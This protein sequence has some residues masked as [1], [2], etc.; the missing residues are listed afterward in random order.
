MSCIR[1]TLDASAGGSE[2]PHVAD[3]HPILAAVE[4][5]T[6][7]WRMVAPDGRE[8]GRIELRRVTN[9]ARVRYKTVWRGEVLGWAATL[10]EACWRLHGAYLA[11][12]GP[13]GGP[14]ADWGGRDA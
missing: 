14:V 7:V 4:G 11:A 8:Y 6:G 10:R 3:W 5:P 9:G 13:S 12:H 1:R 2:A